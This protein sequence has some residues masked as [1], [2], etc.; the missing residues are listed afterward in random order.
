M[1][2]NH[3]SNKYVLTICHMPDIVPGTGDTMVTK[4][5][6]AFRLPPIHQEGSMINK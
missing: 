5:Y 3:S 4:I 1:S 6:S 2:F